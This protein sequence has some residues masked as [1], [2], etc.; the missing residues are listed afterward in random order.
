MRAKIV[1]IVNNEVTTTDLK[2]VVGKLKSETIGKDIE[3]ACSVRFQTRVLMLT[4][5]HPHHFFIL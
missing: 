3:T 5:S 4:T 1:E 2:T